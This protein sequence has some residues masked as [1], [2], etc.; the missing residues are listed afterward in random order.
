MISKPGLYLVGGVAAVVLVASGFYLKEGNRH[1]DALILY[2][3]M[4]IRQVELSFHDPERVE[5]ILVQ[6]GER[7]KR[8]QLLAAQALER[9]QYSR[10]Q[11]AAKVDVQQHQL[12]KLLH[13]SRP[14]EI[15]KA[16]NDVKAAEAAVV[17]AKK[18]L[19]RFQALVKRKLSSAESLDRAQAQYDAA[20]QSLQ[21]LKQQYAL[22]EIGPRR[23]DIQAA[24]AQLKADQA[25]LQLADKVLADARLYAPQDGVVQNR[26]LEP[27]DM[28]SAQKPV[29]TLALREPLWAR[30]YVAEADLGRL[31]YGLPASLASDSFPDKSYRGW[32]GYMSPT[33]EF[34]PKTVETTELRTSL[35]YQVRIYACDPDDQLRLGMPVTV[36]IDTQQ[37]PMA[38]PSCEPAL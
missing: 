9:F 25:A 2:G 27:G 15:G 11:A 12:D 14:Q 19:V 35:V 8:G 10:D 34:T 6:E 24:Q 17:L 28:A 7:V 26:I 1:T 4:D 22:T 30:T 3:N 18:E 21:A 23:E 33:A 5:Q 37:A 16:G 36:R 32:V 20:Q 13:G 29:L 38:Q 31:R